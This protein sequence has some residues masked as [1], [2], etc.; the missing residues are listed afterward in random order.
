VKCADCRFWSGSCRKG[1]KGR[2]ALDKAC[3]QFKP[4]TGYYGSQPMPRTVPLA[5]VVNE[6]VK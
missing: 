3:N 2:L 4:K 6:E 1:V 5:A